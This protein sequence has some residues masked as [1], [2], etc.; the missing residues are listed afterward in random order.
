MHRSPDTHTG[1]GPWPI[2]GTRLPLAWVVAWGLAAPAVPAS[3]AQTDAALSEIVK[4]SS[5]VLYEGTGAQAYLDVIGKLAAQGHCYHLTLGP[6][7]FDH[8][9][10]LEE[11]VP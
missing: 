6:D 2:A 10:L 7:L 11:L 1:R 3:A 4:N 5:W 9:N 8:P